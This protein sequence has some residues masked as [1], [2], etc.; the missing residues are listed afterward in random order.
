MTGKNKGELQ[1]RPDGVGKLPGHIPQPRFAADP[2][3]RRKLLSGELQALE[4]LKASEKMT[5][6]LMD[7]KRIDKNCGHF[8]KQCPSMDEDER[9]DTGKAV[10]EHHF[11]NHEHCRSWC[12]RKTLTDEQKKKGMQHCR[13]KKKDAKLHHKLHGIMSHFVAKECLADLCHGM[14]TQ[15]NE[16]FN[17]TFSWF[18]P[19]NKVHCGT[20]SLRNRLG[21]PIEM[22]GVGY[23]AHHRRLVTR[24][25]IQITPDLKHFLT[26]KDQN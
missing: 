11:D 4:K 20:G 22:H 19:K 13:C 18:A 12:S 21:I 26:A 17:N 25:G 9:V 23:E 10:P 24:L 3:H 8:L 6:T 2:N 15:V 5:L 1:D 14:N 16:S 7:V